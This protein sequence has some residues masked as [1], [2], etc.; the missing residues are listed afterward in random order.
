MSIASSGQGG[1]ERRF[2][3]H[4]RRVLFHLDHRDRDRDRGHDLLGCL[5]REL[6]MPAGILLRSRLP[7][8]PPLLAGTEAE[9]EP[10]VVVFWGPICLQVEGPLKLLALQFA[11][12]AAMFGP[13]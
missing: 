2:R 7:P 10:V 5:D 4:D 13:G 1:I 12:S 9:Q 6:E 3:A 8:R 11:A